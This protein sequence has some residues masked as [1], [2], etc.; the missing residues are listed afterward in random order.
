MHSVMFEDVGANE[1]TLALGS[2]SKL[3]LAG[4]GE[5][6]KRYES[7]GC[8]HF[9]SYSASETG[10]RVQEYSYRRIPKLESGSP[11]VRSSV[12]KFYLH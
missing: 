1:G 8:S 6:S 9:C 4:S 10:S 2:P 12:C 7:E 3:F 11:R 5:C